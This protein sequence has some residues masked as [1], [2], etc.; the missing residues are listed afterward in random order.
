ME[1][2]QLQID[3]TVLLVII[4]FILDRLKKVF[5]WVF[6]IIQIEPFEKVGTITPNTVFLIRM[7]NSITESL[8]FSFCS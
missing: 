3:S 1:C 4:Y 7:L 6:L 2:F 5:N 8:A